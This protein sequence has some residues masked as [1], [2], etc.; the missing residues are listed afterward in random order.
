MIPGPGRVLTG[1]PSQAGVLIRRADAG[2]DA[3]GCAGVY[4][5]Y[6]RNTA[7]S[8]EEEPPDA[9]EMAR[10]IEETTAG[11]PWL[12]AE[13]GGR[14]VGYAYASQHRPRAAYRWTVD[15]AI[16]ID[17]A[18]HRQGLGRALYEA[19][20]D[21]LCEQGLRMACAGITQPNPAS[22]A[23]HEN[24]GFGLV[25]VYRQIGW[26]AGAWHDVAWYQRRLAADADDPPP[27][28]RAPAAV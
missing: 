5:P 20:F 2:A 24:V 15:V 23:L 14:V 1:R 13:V 9:H 27:E 18:H 17:S 16:Y 22:V 10:R 8:F 7:I 11:Y 3:A 28:P 25:G 4:A 26:K 12:V 19:L 6:V 21:L